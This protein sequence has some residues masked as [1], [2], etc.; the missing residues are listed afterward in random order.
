MSENDSMNMICLKCGQFQP[1]ADTCTSCGAVIAKLKK[2]QTP[3]AEPVPESTGANILGDGKNSNVFVRILGIIAV[4]AV[5]AGLL[6]VM[7]PREMI[8]SE[9][10]EAKKSGSQLR[11]FKIQGRVAADSSV[12]IVAVQSGDGQEMS[13]LKIEDSTSVAYVTYDSRDINS[14]LSEGDLVSIVGRFDSTTLVGGSPKPRRFF[15]ALASSIEVLESGD[16]K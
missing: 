10:V 3:A 15:I 1:K 5:C 12:S 2:P 8:L 11:G 7:T 13:S 4:I 16:G 6:Y 9:F 14:T